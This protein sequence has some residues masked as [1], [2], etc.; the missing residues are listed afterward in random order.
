MTKRADIVR[1]KGRRERGRPWLRCEDCVRRDIS[2]VGVFGEWKELAED[3][4]K[5]RSFVAK[6]GQKLGPINPHL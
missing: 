6:A 1:E 4:E 3:R 5:W 2:K